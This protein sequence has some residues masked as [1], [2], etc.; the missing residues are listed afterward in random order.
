MKLF[1]LGK[2]SS[3][4]AA[5]LARMSRLEL[6]DGLEK[7]QV[8]PFEHMAAKDIHPDALNA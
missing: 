1:E 6:L 5:E 4:R 3:G 7:H 2:L 8:V